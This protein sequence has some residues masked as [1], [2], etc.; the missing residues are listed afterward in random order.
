MRGIVAR[1]SYS[2]WLQW[3]SY[4]QCSSTCV[5]ILL[6][7]DR[8]LYGV[9]PGC[10]GAGGCN[11]HGRIRSVSSPYGGGHGT[12]YC[13]ASTCNLSKKGCEQI[14]LTE[15][16]QWRDF[17]KIAENGKVVCVLEWLWF[18]VAS[19]HSCVCWK[20][21]LESTKLELLHRAYVIDN[22]WSDTR[23]FDS[24]RIKILPVH[25]FHFGILF[26]VIISIVTE[27]LYV[28]S[29]Q[30]IHFL[31]KFQALTLSQKS[32]LTCEKHV[33]RQICVGSKFG[34]TNIASFRVVFLHCSFF[35]EHAAMEYSKNNFIFVFTVVVICQS[36]VE[37][38]LQPVWNLWLKSSFTLTTDLCHFLT[39]LYACCVFRNH[40]CL[41]I[42]T[43][44]HW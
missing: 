24:P 6:K 4:S 33:R 22:S 8:K 30:T 3:D 19:Y 27:R 41:F 1:E 39:A 42:D 34:A 18:S 26:F 17:F 16:E 23:G 29:E 32:F 25:G 5:C 21:F 37:Q 20:C 12:F 40:R 14:L 44:A 31:P 2:Q 35:Y 15:R 36:K 28:E 10:P 43:W 11:A 7:V 13:R 9:L 38:L